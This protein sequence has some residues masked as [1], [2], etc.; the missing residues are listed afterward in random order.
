MLF[1]KEVHTPTGT[2]TAISHKLPCRF[3]AQ[4][5]KSHYSLKTHLPTTGSGNKNNKNVEKCTSLLEI[6]G[7][8]TQ[9]SS[10]DGYSVD[11][12]YLKGC[13]SPLTVEFGVEQCR[14]VNL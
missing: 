1:R 13:G 10:T 2:N 8:G 4:V 11:V 7:K 6:F 14:F 12:K 5:L 3:P 9:A